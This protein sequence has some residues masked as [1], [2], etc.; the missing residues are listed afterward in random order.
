M[1]VVALTRRL[2]TLP[3]FSPR[4]PFARLALQP[5]RSSQFFVCRIP[6]HTTNNVEEQGGGGLTMVINVAP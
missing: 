2:S 6:H 4:R 1:T 5:S 3:R